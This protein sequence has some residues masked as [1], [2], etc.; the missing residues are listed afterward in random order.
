M[1]EEIY[2]EQAFTE[3]RAA[4]R[5]TWTKYTKMQKP[6]SKRQQIIG[7]YE[8]RQKKSKTGFS[9]KDIVRVK[10]EVRTKT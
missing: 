3:D 1:M 7:C 4:S 2:K 8:E 10:V 9:H 5:G 6:G